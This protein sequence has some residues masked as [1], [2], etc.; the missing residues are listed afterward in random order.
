V[1]AASAVGGSAAPSRRDATLDA[2][3]AVE[4][5]RRVGIIAR[6][7]AASS[8]L[9]SRKGPG[10]GLGVFAKAPRMHEPDWHRSSLLD[11]L[12]RTFRA[13]YGG[14]RFPHCVKAAAD[15]LEAP[16]IVGAGHRTCWRRCRVHR[17]GDLY[18]NLIS[19]SDNSP[20]PSSCCPLMTAERQSS[21]DFRVN[22]VVVTSIAKG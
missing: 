3:A 6:G 12:R 11:Y 8:N 17:E 15:L 21:Q 4:Q 10:V 2:V 20:C 1:T 5:S 13:G 18:L 7:S 22:P 9:P 14:R 16:G 19:S